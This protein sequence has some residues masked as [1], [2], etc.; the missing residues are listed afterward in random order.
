MKSQGNGLNLPLTFAYASRKAT[1]I[2]SLK[3]TFVTNTARHQRY[4][5]FSTFSKLRNQR[6]GV[7]RQGS[8][9]E[10]GWQA[11]SLEEDLE[12]SSFAAPD[13][14]AERCAKCLAQGNPFFLCTLA[15]VCKGW[16]RRF[17]QSH[18]EA[19]AVWP[20]L[21]VHNSRG[22]CGGRLFP[23]SATCVVLK[24]GAV[25]LKA[26][27]FHRGRTKKDGSKRKCLALR[28]QP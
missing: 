14:F 27:T 12:Q 8:M 9:K 6:G 24:V 7:D 10:M 17:T 3:P 2:S 20:Q 25:D 5:A 11:S 22:Q 18:Y 16:L 23:F 19:F 21:V 4:I 13:L 28:R 1:K 26:Q 15:S